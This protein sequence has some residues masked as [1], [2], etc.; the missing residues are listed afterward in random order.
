MSI[1]S[2]NKIMNSM[3]LREINKILKTINGLS[4]HMKSLTDKELQAKT[5]EFKQRLKNNKETLDE[6]LPEAYAVMREALFR[7]NKQYP[8]DVQILGAIVMHQ[9]DIAE[10]KTGEGKTL[11]ATMPLY[12]N[13]LLGSGVFLITVN[14]YL[15]DRDCSEMR[16]VFEWM[17][18][19]VASRTPSLNQEKISD[20]EKKRIYA[21]DIVY[22]TNS[23]LGF[24]YLLDNLVSEKDSKSQHSYNFAIVDEVDS[25]LLDGAQTPLVISGVPRLQSNLFEMIQNFVETMEESHYEIDE[26]KQQV[27]ITSEG[28]EYVCSF[29]SLDLLERVKNFQ[30]LRHIYL[31]LKANFLYKNEK[32][33][34]VLNDKIVLLDDK[35]GRLLQ[36]TKLQGGLHQAIEAKEKVT[37]TNQ[38]RSMASITFENLFN[39]FTKLAGMSGTGQSEEDEFIETYGM[40]VVQIP[41]NLPTKRIDLPT[42]FYWN[43]E[44]KIQA[45]IE[46]LLEYHHNGRPILLITDSVVLSEEYSIILTELGIVHNVLNAYNEVKE[47]QIIK[48]AGQWKAVTI[49]T[50]MAGRGTD[51]KVAP[52]V[53]EAGGLAVLGTQIMANQ[54][55]DWQLRGRAG[56]QGDPGTSQFFVSLDDPLIKKY[57]KASI[58]KKLDKLIKKNSAK[59]HREIKGNKYQRLVNKVQ[60]S[61][62]AMQE[63]ARKM[64]FLYN[65]SL[66]FQRELVY[67]FRDKLLEQ[68]HISTQWVL[69]IMQNEIINMIDSTNEHTEESISRYILENISYQFNG[70]PQNLNLASE[71]ELKDF[72]LDLVEQSLESK[73]AKFKGNGQIVWFYR[74]AILKAVDEAWIEQV[75]YVQQL[76]AVVLYRYTAQKNPVF[77]YTEEAL[78]SFKKMKIA[79]RKSIVRC[80][81]LSS[82]EKNKEG[83]SVIFFG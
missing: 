66:S 58:Q 55:I 70:L 39:L 42:R 63:Q 78:E 8:Y 83:E 43:K 15:A 57:G 68:T 81:L 71:N 60:Y 3:R 29:F 79:M 5:Q 21:S 51:I 33:Y 32:N 23:V 11:T 40:R 36:S 31:A 6:L 9:G 2:K 22:T 72:L 67:E 64:T 24:D 35:S 28:T 7:V 10:M 14:E 19:T 48:E 59:I 80:I 76:K 77:E 16:H 20:E 25:V 1:L 61:N 69:D 18:L 52:E 44:A 13:A 34:V 65:E 47:A 45:V 46:T 27:W 56:R 74:T 75:D 49:A 4:D 82:I 73:I 50:A 17:G 41:T 53:I 30:L 12:L 38:N 62:E 26:D 54:R 37:L